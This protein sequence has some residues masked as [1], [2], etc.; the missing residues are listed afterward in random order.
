MTCYNPARFEHFFF[1]RFKQYDS[2]PVSG[3]GLDHRDNEKFK[4]VL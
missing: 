1:V 2:F 3:K 4:L